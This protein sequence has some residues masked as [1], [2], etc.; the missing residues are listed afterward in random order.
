M[1]RIALAAALVAVAS[2]ACGSGTTART[3]LVDYKH[4]EFASAFLDY[5]PK[6]V[7][8]HPG[9]TVVF[10]QAWSGEPHS[11]TM[12]RYANKLGRLVK[13][14]L[15][16]FAEKGYEGLPPDP[17]KEIRALED[18]LPWMTDDDGKV[19]QNAAQPCFLNKGSPPKKASE[20]CTKAQQRQPEFTGK[21]TYYNSGF[22][23]YE[24]PNG[25]TFE[26]KLSK[27]M[28]PGRHFFYCNYHGE[29]MSG[30]VNVKPSSEKIESQSDI[31]R[32]AN[33]QI[34]AQARPLLKEFRRAQRGL[35]EPPE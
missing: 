6:E 11:V 32:R 12:G 3:V 31:A 13:P 8:A 34:E 21:Q 26:M 18:K 20:P 30:Y 33:R 35:V 24:G 7:D 4:D 29:F 23:P 16:I 27:D 25:D 22:I 9:D 14:Y 17:P 2:T 15:K 19:Q 1:K 28:K 10:R 5:F